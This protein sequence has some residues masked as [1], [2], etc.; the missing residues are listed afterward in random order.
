MAG[1]VRNRRVSARKM[2]QQQSLVHGGED[3]Y[4]LLED[5]FVGED[6]DSN[7]SD[8]EVVVTNSDATPVLTEDIGLNDETD[9]D[10]VRLIRQNGRHGSGDKASGA[11]LNGVHIHVPHKG[12]M[13]HESFLSI[14]LQ[15]LF[16][17]T[18]AG[19]GMVGAGIVLDIVQHWKVFEEINELFILVP[20]LLGLKGNLEMTLASR[21]STQVKL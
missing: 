1:V 18:V 7:N 19:L 9:D 2:G 16:P 10:T 17:F 12:G 20:A 15:I 8:D 6:L 3:K 13:A 4:Q 14:T 11:E 5:A 21:L